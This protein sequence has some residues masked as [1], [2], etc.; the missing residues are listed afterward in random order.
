MLSNG[1]SALSR[2]LAADRLLSPPLNLNPMGLCLIVLVMP[3]LRILSL[4]KVHGALA[5][6]SLSNTIFHPRRR[7]ASF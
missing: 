5:G 6:V 3:V 7:P 2:S 1:L 4:S